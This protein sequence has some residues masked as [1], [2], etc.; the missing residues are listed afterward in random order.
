MLRSL[1]PRRLPDVL[2]SATSNPMPV[3][4][5]V[6]RPTMARWP[7]ARRWSPR[8]SRDVGERFLNNAVDGAFGL[9]AV[10]DPVPDE[11]SRRRSGG[12]DGSRRPLI[13]VLPRDRDRRE[14]TDA[15]DATDRARCAVRGV[16]AGLRI[17]KQRAG[18]AHP[19]DAP[20]SATANWTLTALS[21][22][23]TSSYSR[24]IRCC[25]PRVDESR[26]QPLRSL[27]MRF[28]RDRAVPSAAARC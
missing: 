13:P 17:G 19:F 7:A 27:A 12:G 21:A 10:D 16:G 23:P 20:R 8:V 26:R 25:S 6:T 3:V 11:R 28:F 2:T 18:C 9:G 4:P 22:C 5:M 1:R 15:G 14:P 24:A